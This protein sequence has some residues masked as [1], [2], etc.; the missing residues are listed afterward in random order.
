MGPR[1]GIKDE[2]PRTEDRVMMMMVTMTMMM[3]M[4][5][6]MMMMVMIM[7]DMMIMTVVYYNTISLATCSE[8]GSAS[9]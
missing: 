7:L 6:T 9:T 8:S 2:G 5:V 1:A 4:M 3:M